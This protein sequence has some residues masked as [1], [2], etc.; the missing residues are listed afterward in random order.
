MMRSLTASNSSTDTVA[1]AVGTVEP[2]SA[3]SP[4]A[5]AAA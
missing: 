4:D 2:A 5:A 3:L 1:D